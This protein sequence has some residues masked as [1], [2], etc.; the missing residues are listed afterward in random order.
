MWNY[1]GST[2]SPLPGAGCC[3]RQWTGVCVLRICLVEDCARY[4]SGWR[5][6][7]TYLHDGPR[8]CE[9]TRSDPGKLIFGC[10]Q[11]NLFL[12]STTPSPRIPDVTFT[13]V[14][15]G[16]TETAMSVF[17]KIGALFGSQM[18][19]AGCGEAKIYSRF[20]AISCVV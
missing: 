2:A 17:F 6:V 19:P 7:W 10:G 16:Q 12:T 4:H 1:A 20:I 15:V 14:G 3:A 8:H 9:R 11:Y 18:A 5:F 13:P